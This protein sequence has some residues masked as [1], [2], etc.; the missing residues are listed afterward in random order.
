M[1]KRR[2][3]SDDDIDQIILHNPQRL[4]TFI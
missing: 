1:M 2:G 4:L 3:F